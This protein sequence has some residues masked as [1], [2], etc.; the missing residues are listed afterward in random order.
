MPDR[1]WEF[2]G[3]QPLYEGFRRMIGRTYRLPNGTEHVFEILDN[4][5][6]VAILALTK[7]RKVVLAR[8]FRTGPQLWLN[9]MPGGIVDADEEPLAAAKREL[10]EETGYSGAFT[11][12]GSAYYSAYAKGRRH[13]VLATDCEILQEP[14][15]E[16]TEDIQ[17]V[18]MDL[19]DFKRQ[20]FAGEMTDAYGALRGLAELKL[21]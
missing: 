18:L 2:L 4:P 9:E 7:D 6:S 15:L 13:A 1:D 5:D 21:I 8:Q 11:Y 17:I 3:E 10:L 12:L 16:E 20:V 19:E 14:H